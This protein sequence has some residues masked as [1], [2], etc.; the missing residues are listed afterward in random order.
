MPDANRCP[1]CDAVLDPRS[2]GP[3]GSMTCSVCG[4][5][6]T[7]RVSSQSATED[8]GFVN[9]YAQAFRKYA[10]FSGRARRR[11]YWY[12]FLANLIMAILLMIVD[13]SLGL[14]RSEVGWGPLGTL[15]S[16]VVLLPGLA[17]AVR[18]LHD[19]NRRG[20]W[21][22]L[23]LIPF[24]GPI[25]LIVFFAEDSGA[26][27]NRFGP[28]PKYATLSSEEQTMVTA[29]SAPDPARLGEYVAALGN[30]SPRVREAAAE[31]LGQLA[32][33]AREAEPALQA[34]AKSDA[35]RRVRVR[36]EWALGRVKRGA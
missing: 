11:E 10:V 14:E 15:Y 18:R 2:L 27:G 13:A 8:Q 24:V 5:Q 16:L 30:S 28:S 22:F 21:L 36:A 19:T 4:A 32:G 29:V 34:A 31:A 35:D 23:A 6:D 25:L 7:A 9:W 20:W 33:A 17:V 1:V 3:D 12:F 26:G